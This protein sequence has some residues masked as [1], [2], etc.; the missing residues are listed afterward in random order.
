MSLSKTYDKSDITFLFPSETKEEDKPSPFHPFFLLP[1]SSDLFH[2]S[3]MLLHIQ[4]HLYCSSGFQFL[5]WFFVFNFSFLFTFGFRFDF[6]RFFSIFSSAAAEW[7]ARS[8][9]LTSPAL[10]ESAPLVSGSAFSLSWLLKPGP[11]LNNCNYLDFVPLRRRQGR[12]I[13]QGSPILFHLRLWCF[14]VLFLPTSPGG[15]LR[16]RR[17]AFRVRWMIDIVDFII[18]SIVLHRLDLLT[19]AAVFLVLLL[20]LPALLVGNRG[21]DFRSS[22]VFSG[23]DP[24]NWIH[25]L[26]ILLI[27]LVN[28]YLL[29]LPLG[30]HQC[31]PV[32]RR[33]NRSFAL[34]KNKWIRGRSRPH[35]DSSLVECRQL[36]ERVRRTEISMIAATDPHPRAVTPLNHRS[37]NRLRQRLMDRQRDEEDKDWVGMYLVLRF[38]WVH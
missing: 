11:R 15:K 20:L 26:S 22:L 24:R 38:A 4:I 12:R 27:L 37:G 2:F 30:F 21:V 1:P 14:R 17:G 13:Y 6:I 35:R 23:P 5:S 9:S 29:P 7:G 32:G 33:S 16:I 28:P 34:L 25:F 19:T 31:S 8:I 10:S 36:V 3:K 18:A